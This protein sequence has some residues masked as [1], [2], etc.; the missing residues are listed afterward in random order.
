MVGV[1][2]P[3]NYNSVLSATYIVTLP[4]SFATKFIHA[5]CYKPYRYH[6]KI[7]IPSAQVRHK[8]NELY[9]HVH[10]ALV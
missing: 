3:G 9:L 4:S 7:L 5:H 10:V 2:W 6:L 8:Y 1:A